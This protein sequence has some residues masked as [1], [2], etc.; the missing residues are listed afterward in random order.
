MRWKHSC[1]YRPSFFRAETAESCISPSTSLLDT[2]MQEEEMIPWDAP[3]LSSGWGRAVFGQGHESKWRSS[4]CLPHLNC[5]SVFSLL[6][7]QYPSWAWAVKPGCPSP[8]PPPAP[9]IPCEQAH[10]NRLLEFG[11]SLG[12]CL[13]SYCFSTPICFPPALWP[14]CLCFQ[15]QQ[16]TLG[17]PAWASLRAASTHPPWALLFPAASGQCPAWPNSNLSPNSQRLLGP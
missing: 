5:S 16:W 8:P 11:L 13:K 6:V 14:S 15:P 4:L 1:D 17:F 9:H 2:L 10:A 12:I 7:C 3:H